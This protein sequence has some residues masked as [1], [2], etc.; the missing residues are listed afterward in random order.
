MDYPQTENY[1]KSVQYREAM[2]NF[3]FG[4]WQKGLV[5]LNELMERYPF[6]LE[7]R[8][9]NQEMQLRARI[10]SDEITENQQ[11]AA[12]KVVTLGVRIGL[13]VF[14][15]LVIVIGF[16]LYAGRVQEQ[17]QQVQERIAKEAFVVDLSAKFRN[18]QSL[19]QAGLYPDA[20]EVFQQV[21]EADPQ[22]PQVDFYIQETNKLA[23]LDQSY[24]QALD[25]VKAEKYQDAYDVFKG[26]AAERSNFRDVMIRIQD[27][28]KNFLIVDA[29]SEA[30]IAFQEQRWFD[31]IKGYEYIRNL[32][33]AYYTQEIEDYLYRSY[34]FAAEEALAQ[35]NQDL[36]TLK[37][38]EDYFSRA[39]AMRPQN[40]EIRA[41]RSL[42]REAYNIRLANSYLDKAE[43]TLV[44]QPDSLNALKIAETYF[45]EALKVRPNDE[46]VL[47]KRDLAQQY[48]N[49]IDNFQLGFWDNAIESMTIVYLADPD[50][51]SGTARQTL[52]EAY[53]ARAR[54]NLIIG[55][56][57]LGLE[58]AQSAAVIAQESPDS[59][60]RL[61]E[62]P[63]CLDIQRAGITDFSNAT[64]G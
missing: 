30:N 14:A 60:L 39:L 49:A 35:E 38:A 24:N 6:D 33:P 63:F 58:D 3:Q 18:G 20:L 57:D 16:R 59:L 53:M 23:A 25:L 40:A 51:A 55:E 43:N 41:R 4:E 48:L 29:L 5:Q 45:T 13:F 56:Y 15:L 7:L 27:L 50:Y 2:E 44:S 34:V 32:D 19:Y 52:Y 61:Y 26:I 28:E 64:C 62:S 42:A 37:L 11:A 22:Y 12:R 10:D 21:K 31:A 46:D 8:S 9:L 1:I 36:D 54:N 17:W 47:L